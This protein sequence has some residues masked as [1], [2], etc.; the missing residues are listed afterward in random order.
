MQKTIR[1]G[2]LQIAPSQVFTQAAHGMD[3]AATSKVKLL[4]AGE[5]KRFWRNKVEVESHPGRQHQEHTP[6][7]SGKVESD[8]VLASTLAHFCESSDF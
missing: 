8:I 2:S 1:A 7:R 3:R 4:F 5:I 6:A